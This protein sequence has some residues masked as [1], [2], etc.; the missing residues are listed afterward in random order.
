[1][2]C[3]LRQAQDE[4]PPQCDKCY[5]PQTFED[6]ALQACIDFKGYPTPATNKQ[7]T[8]FRILFVLLKKKSFEIITR[9]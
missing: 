7:Q 2:V 1:M 5:P 4:K 3:G 8:I 6:S 9:G